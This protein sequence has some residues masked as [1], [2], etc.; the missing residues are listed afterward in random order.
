M[1]SSLISV[2]E[3]SSR[4][5]QTTMLQGHVQTVRDLGQI[6]FLKLRDQSGLVQVIVERPELLEIA[7]TISVETPVRVEGSVVMQPKSNDSFELHAS[8]ILILS[9]LAE[10]L[11]VEIGKA[12]KM[13]NLSLT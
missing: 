11:P 4:Q 5:G 3:L 9:E 8:E 2:G 7:R 13:K 12:D 6:I 1:E 10:P